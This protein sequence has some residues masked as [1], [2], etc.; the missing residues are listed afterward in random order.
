VLDDDQEVLEIIEGLLKKHSIQHYRLFTSTGEF[1]RYLTADIHVCVIDHYLPD[2]ITGVEICKEIKAVSPNSYIIIISG[3]DSKDVVIQ[4][5][6]ACADKYV[7]KAKPGH[8]ETLIEYLNEGLV[9]A[10]QRVEDVELLQRLR[11][12]S[13]ERRKRFE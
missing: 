5:L 13:E 1:L 4:Y 11:R 9:K 12:S 3:Q 10:K 7:D 8:L 2:G 6:N